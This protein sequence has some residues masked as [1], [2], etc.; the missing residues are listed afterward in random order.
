MFY[1]V[2]SDQ[3]IGRST[4]DKEVANALGLMLQ[5]EQEIVYGPNGKRYLKGTE[6]PL[7]EKSYKQKRAA[8]YPSIAD[9]L[10]MMY[11]DIVNGTETW[12]E[13]VGAVKLKYPK[14]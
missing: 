3:T 14:E 5:T 2:L 6:P 1:E 4:K 11:W 10:D 12:R 7:P 13:A 9:Q 8:A